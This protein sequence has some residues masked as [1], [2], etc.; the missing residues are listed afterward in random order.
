[1]ADT[2]NPFAPGEDPTPRAPP[3]TTV[4]GAAARGLPAA[5]PLA[6][7]AALLYAGLQSLTDPLPLS[8]TAAQVVAALCAAFALPAVAAWSWR[9]SRA[10]WWP[11]PLSA[12]VLLLTQ[13]G[14]SLSALHS[15]GLEIVWHSTI[16]GAFGFLWL[17]TTLA[18]LGRDLSW[19]ALPGFTAATSLKYVAVAASSQL[20][21]PVV[22]VVPLL[23]LVEPVAARHPYRAVLPAVVRSLRPAWGAVLFGT[24]AS[25]VN[26]GAVVMVYEVGGR[27]LGLEGILAVEHHPTINAVGEFL[28]LLGGWGTSAVVLALYVEAVPDPDD[29]LG[30]TG[31]SRGAGAAG[32]AGP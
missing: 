32:A 22:V 15:L 4:L 16:S 21:L 14:D 12:A 28:W 30:S 23:M 19:E 3:A 1:M 31:G 11:V 26:L 6:G 29:A 25:A 5:V 8:W 24:V 27:L 7:I 20:C 17:R 2:D 10:L 13:P 9:G 18:A